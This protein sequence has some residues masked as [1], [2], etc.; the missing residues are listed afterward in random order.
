MM[1]NPTKRHTN[2]NYGW[3]GE[4]AYI[5]DFADFP[6]TNEDLNKQAEAFYKKHDGKA[7]YDIEVIG[8]K[9]FDY[10]KKEFENLKG[11]DSGGRRRR[12]RKSRRKSRRKRRKS[13]RKSRRKNKSRKRRRR[14]RR[15]RR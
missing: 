5:P 13:R 3:V 1:S 9:V 12:R 14:T 15:R 11:P 10:N 2:W 7:I 6:I 4:D 8:V